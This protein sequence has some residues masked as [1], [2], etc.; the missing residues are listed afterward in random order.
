MKP[1]P[2]GYVAVVRIDYQGTAQDGKMRIQRSGDQ[3][4]LCGMDSPPHR[5][6]MTATSQR[7]D[8]VCA[9]LRPTRPYPTTPRNP[10]PGHRR[11]PPSQPGPPNPRPPPNQ[12]APPSL[13]GPPR[14]PS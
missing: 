10:H 13:L 5:D 1:F 4:A 8:T 9:W 11:K 12:P 2:D 14:H 3:W 6:G 7:A